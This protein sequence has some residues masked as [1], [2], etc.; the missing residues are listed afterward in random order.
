MYTYDAKVWDF[1]IVQGSFSVS[2]CQTLALR[3][4]TFASLYARPSV[5][6]VNSGTHV[7]QSYYRLD[8][9][10]YQSGVDF[11]SPYS[12]RPLKPLTPL[13]GVMA[14]LFSGNLGIPLLV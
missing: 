12:N 2:P 4:A 9:S 8:F 11:M 7:P 3:F 5:V 10:I 6:Q 13:F 14:C 1:P